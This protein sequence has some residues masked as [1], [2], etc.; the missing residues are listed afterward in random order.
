MEARHLT[1]ILE[2]EK[3]G[4]LHAFCPALRGCHTLGDTLDEAPANIREAIEVY[5]DDLKAAPGS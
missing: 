5:L 2:R 4:G 1:V 3:D